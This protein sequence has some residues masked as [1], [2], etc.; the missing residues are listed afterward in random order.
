MTRPNGRY[1]VEPAPEGSQVT[2]NPRPDVRGIATIME[3]LITFN[4]TGSGPGLRRAS[5][6][7]AGSD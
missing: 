3:P 1:L 4:P 7:T 5:S 6:T 2:L